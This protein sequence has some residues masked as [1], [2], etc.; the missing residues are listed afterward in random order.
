MSA[1]ESE[2]TEVLVLL[3]PYASSPEA[4]VLMRRAEAMLAD[5]HAGPERQWAQSVG[6]WMDSF[7][8]ASVRLCRR[9]SVVARAAARAWQA[10]QV[11]GPAKVT[12]VLTSSG[13]AS[14]PGAEWQRRYGFA[15]A[16]HVARRPKAYPREQWRSRFFLVVRA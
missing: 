12:V 10:E 6:R 2:L 7:R 11:D 9:L 5:G 13:P 8:H 14:D 15:L 4:R 16:A 3:R 1:A